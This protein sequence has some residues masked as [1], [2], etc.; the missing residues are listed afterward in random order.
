MITLLGKSAATITMILDNLES[1]CDFQPITI[2]N[3]LKIEDSIPYKNKLFSIFEESEPVFGGGGVLLGVYNPK[4]KS[5]VVKLFNVGL[6][7]FRRAI[8][9]SAQISSVAELGR[10]IVVC[11][12]VSIAAYAKLGDYVNV[13]RNASIGHHTVIGDFVSIC[14]SATICGNVKIGMGSYIGAGAVIIDGVTVGENV[15]VGAGSVVIKD[16]SNGYVV[17]GN[18]SNFIKHNQNKI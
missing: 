5:D 2:I 16:V 13:N 18:P 15:V 3:N 1:V 14:P 11:S 7:D 12:N 9:K 4:V 17:V 10:G 8:H 6:N